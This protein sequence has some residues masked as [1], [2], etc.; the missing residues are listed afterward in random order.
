[1]LQM[2][3]H[4]AD[5]VNPARPFHLAAAWADRIVQ[6]LLEQVS[7]QAGGQAG[8]RRQAG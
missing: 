1:M 8:G 7:G 4:L 2:L 5:L 3:V 6:E